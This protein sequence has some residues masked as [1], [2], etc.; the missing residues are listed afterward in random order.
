ME[1]D[2]VTRTDGSRVCVCLCV[3]WTVKIVC[4]EDS[5]TDAEKETRH[6][7]LNVTCLLPSYD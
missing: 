5:P 3:L 6:N 7:V 2:A 1:N 4:S